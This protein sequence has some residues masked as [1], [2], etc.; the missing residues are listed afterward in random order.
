MTKQ[1]RARRS[2]AEERLPVPPVP[3]E[4]WRILLDPETAKRPPGWAARFYERRPD[5]REVPFDWWAGETGKR[6]M[7]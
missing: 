1:A 6:P 3:D 7:G 5:L 4:I 2:S